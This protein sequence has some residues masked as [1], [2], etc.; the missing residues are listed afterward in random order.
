MLPLRTNLWEEARARHIDRVC[1]RFEQAWRTVG[2][3]A[4]TP[5]I[6]EFLH[7]DGFAP[8]IAPDLFAELLCGQRPGYLA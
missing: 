2:T 6:E 7:A 8:D 5:R 1:D 4:A 3:S